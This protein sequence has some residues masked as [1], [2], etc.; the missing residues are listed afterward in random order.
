MGYTCINIGLNAKNTKVITLNTK[1]IHFLPEIWILWEL[2]IK[3][4]V[5]SDQSVVEGQ[6]LHHRLLVSPQCLRHARWHACLLWTALG[7]HCLIPRPCL[8]FLVSVS[9]AILTI[10]LSLQ[11]CPPSLQYIVK[12]SKFTDN[13]CWFH[14]NYL[15]PDDDKETP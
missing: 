4:R 14:F 1:K 15:L 6:G 5:A 7:K 10:A 3:V 13:F 11:H 8:A 12:I 9:T 2:K